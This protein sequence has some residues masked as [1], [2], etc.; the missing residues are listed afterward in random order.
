MHRTAPVPQQ[1]LTQV[2]RFIHLKKGRILIQI[3]ATAPKE[4]RL[5][6]EKDKTNRLRLRK[7]KITDVP[8]KSKTR[9]SPIP[10]SCK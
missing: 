4:S 10:S 7:A 9:L 1:N 5:H 3:L 6:V 2:N 8:D